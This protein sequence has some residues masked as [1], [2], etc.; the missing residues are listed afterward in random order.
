MPSV[1]LNVE[2]TLQL[3]GYAR[4]KLFREALDSGARRMMLPSRSERADAASH[5]TG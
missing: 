2:Q 4:K 5:P 3:V 1:Q